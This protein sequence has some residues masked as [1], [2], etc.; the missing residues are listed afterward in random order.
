M[1]IGLIIFGQNLE[2]PTIVS[3]ASSISSKFDPHRR[4]LNGTLKGLDQL[5]K[6]YKFPSSQFVL[7]VSRFKGMYII[8][9]AIIIKDYDS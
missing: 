1:K 8:R 2:I 7:L 6:W 9:F 5:S 3:A 4:S